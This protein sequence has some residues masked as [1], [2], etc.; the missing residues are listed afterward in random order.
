V[1]RR[2]VFSNYDSPTNPFYGGGGARAIHE[3]ARRLATHHEVR[4]VAGAFPGCRDGA[5][6][7]V[8]YEHIGR[9]GA[10]G[11]LGQLG[12]QFR[13]PGRARRSDFDL[14]VE[15]LTP[16]FSTACLQKFT[17]KPVV[18]LTQVLAGKAMARKYKLPFGAIERRGL[19]TYRHAIALSEFLKGEI[20]RANPRAN[21]TVIPNGVPAELIRQTVAREERHIL[22]LGRLDVNQKGLDLLLDAAAG[23]VGNVDVQLVIAGGGTARDEA[24][25]RRRVEFL[26]LA[27]RVRFTG[28][29]AGAQKHDLLRQ[30]FFLAMP[31]RFEASPLVMLEAFA[32]GVPVVLYDIPELHETPD[33]CCVKAPPFD[34]AGL[35]R[36]MFLLLRDGP[37]RAALGRAAKAYSAKFDWDDLAARYEDFFESILQ[38]G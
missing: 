6:D 16:P 4:V 33:T 25:L 19:R 34:V 26:R 30:A 35:S 31:S 24:W 37:R 28:P 23:L 2:L 38:T 12:F 8:T 36:A 18:A 14:W 21:V 11:K 3:I 7:G 29:V 20:L 15:S 1:K 5:V 27:D 22:F 17:P 10:S 9:S 13:L 32:C